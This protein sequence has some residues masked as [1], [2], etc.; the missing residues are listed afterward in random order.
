MIFSVVELIV[1]GCGQA[2]KGEY[3]RASFSLFKLGGG[4][5]ETE[6]HAKFHVPPEPRERTPLS[7]PFPP[8]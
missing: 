2:P 7:G 6:S 4:A 1:V 5:R 8:S 3:R